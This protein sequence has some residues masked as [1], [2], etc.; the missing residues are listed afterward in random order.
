MINDPLPKMLKLLEKGLKMGGDTH[1]LEDILDEIKSGHK[2]SFASGNTWA[3]TQVLDFPRR[4]VLELFLVVGHGKDLS[5]LEEQI[6]EYARSIGADFIRTSGR[7]G[8]KTHAKKMGWE[9]SHVVYTKR[10]SK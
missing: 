2:Q 7:P 1:T 3:I 4:R 10:V 9:L 8:W 6:T 5:V